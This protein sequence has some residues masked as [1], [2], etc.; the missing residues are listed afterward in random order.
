MFGEMAKSEPPKVSPGRRAAGQGVG[1]QQISP[2][3]PRSL[4]EGGLGHLT[5]EDLQVLCLLF[6]PKGATSGNEMP[7]HKHVFLSSAVIIVL[8]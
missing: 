4:I 1:K 2:L 8:I 7:H 5:A 3:S 6:L